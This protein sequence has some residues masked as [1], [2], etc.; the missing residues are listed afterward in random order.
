MT[1]LY[2]TLF[3]QDQSIVKCFSGSFTSRTAQSWGASSS[4]TFPLGKPHPDL[5][6]YPC[7][8]NTYTSHMQKLTEESFTQTIFWLLKKRIFISSGFNLLTLS[9]V[10]SRIIAPY[11][12]TPILYSF[13]W[14]KTFWTS[15]P[16]GSRNGQWLKS[17]KK[18]V[19]EN[20][21]IRH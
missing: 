15:S 19:K 9:R 6:R 12:G 20:E 18:K 7:T 17:K 3:F 21:S 16:W 8:S 11:V 10:S 4:L 5:A 13:H 2:V 14:S 1:K